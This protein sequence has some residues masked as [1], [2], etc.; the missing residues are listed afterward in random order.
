MKEII[1]NLSSIFWWLSVIVAGIIIN[2]IGIYIKPQL[3]KHLSSGPDWWCRQSKKARQD[4]RAKIEELQNNH[5]AQIMAG[6]EMLHNQV[7][8][9]VLILISWTLYMSQSMTSIF[10]LLIG[11]FFFILLQTPIV[12]K[13]FNYLTFFIVLLI[14]SIFST[15]YFFDIYE[16]AILS[17]GKD[18]TLTGRTLLWQEILN[19]K[20]N[21]IIGTGWDSFWLGEL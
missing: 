1:R 8:S 15:Q 3:D 13:N 21:S 14:V 9:A 6:F 11:I 5:H 10:G 16:K 4:R 18:L 7:F 17:L 12:K 20:I 19:I 2:L